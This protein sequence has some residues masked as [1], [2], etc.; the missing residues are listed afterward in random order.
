MVN[1]HLPAQEV[2]SVQNGKIMKEQST[3]W[4]VEVGTRRRFQK[5]KENVITEQRDGEWD[6]VFTVEASQGTI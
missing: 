4:N 5:N 1:L 3:D 6:T 2:I